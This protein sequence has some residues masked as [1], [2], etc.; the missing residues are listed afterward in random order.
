MIFGLIGQLP[1]IVMI[2]VTEAFQVN[3]KVTVN[4][5]TDDQNLICYAGKVLAIRDGWIEDPY[6]SISVD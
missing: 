1:L 3:D 4:F 2:Q 6:Q 5:M